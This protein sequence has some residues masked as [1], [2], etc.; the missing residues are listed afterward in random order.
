MKLPH[1]RQ[2]LHLAAGAAALPALPSIAKAQ[3]YPSRPVRTVV[4]F[5][6]GAANDVNGRLIAQWLS[7]RLGQPFIVENRP[8]GGGNIGAAE[9]IRSRP[10]GYTLLFLSISHSINETFYNHLPYS[11]VRD[12]TP[13]A[14]LSEQAM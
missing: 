7:E 10:D 6:A 2:F 12:I 13:I 3:A 5:A 11:I 9:V 4:T 8:G 14:S 1:R